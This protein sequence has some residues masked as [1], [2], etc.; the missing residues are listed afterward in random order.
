[1]GEKKKEPHLSI[2][3]KQT[4][5]DPDNKFQHIY[6]ITHL[7]EQ[8]FHFFFFF[9]LNKHESVNVPARKIGGDANVGFDGGVGRENEINRP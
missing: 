9:L 6:Q 4:K 8:K 3:T 2:R 5:I 7:N 1:M